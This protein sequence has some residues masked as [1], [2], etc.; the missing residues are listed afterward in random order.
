MTPIPASPIPESPERD[1]GRL[2]PPP[3]D[4]E[5]PPGA[6]A[7][8]ASAPREPPG[9]SPTGGPEA[10]VPALTAAAVLD[11]SDPR[12]PLAIPGPEKMCT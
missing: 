6:A 5:P 8:T 1:D 3:V 2:N 12:R 4:D 10:L 11:C 9:A 7:L